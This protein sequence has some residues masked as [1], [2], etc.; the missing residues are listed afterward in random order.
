M[1]I[2]PTDEVPLPTPD[3]SPE[4]TEITAEQERQNIV[5]A[6]F[7]RSVIA[8]EESG[9]SAMELQSLNPTA[10]ELRAALATWKIQ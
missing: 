1:S 5:T 6:A 9:I 4:V 10:V 8:N 3:P 7:R 2:P